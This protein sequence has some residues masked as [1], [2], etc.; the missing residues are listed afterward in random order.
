M[1]HNDLQRVKMESAD[2]CLILASATTKDPYQTDAANIMRVIAVKNFASHI[3][4]IV[5]LL[6]TENKVKQLFNFACE[7]TLL[8]LNK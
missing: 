2:A 5:Q 1:D 6:Q 8:K 7:F 3:R 4:I